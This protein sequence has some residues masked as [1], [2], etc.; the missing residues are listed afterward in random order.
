MK[1]IVIN[2]ELMQVEVKAICRSKKHKT[3]T[4]QAISRPKDQSVLASNRYPN[5]KKSKR[6]FR[7]S[8]RDQ[9]FAATDAGVA[10]PN[11][12]NATA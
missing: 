3:K 6:P 2:P 11:D 1:I 8:R 7:N 10:R 9:A 4:N 5:K 12:E